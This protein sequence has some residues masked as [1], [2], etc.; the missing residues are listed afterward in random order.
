MSN[1]LSGLF[2][3]LFGT[4]GLL[5]A[6]IAARRKRPQLKLWVKG[7]GV[8][9]V[10]EPNDVHIFLHCKVDNLSSES[11]SISEAHF[12]FLNKRESEI[13]WNATNVKLYKLDPTS[14]DPKS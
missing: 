11:N 5:W 14:I 13:I 1:V 4:S 7:D 6:V 3:A 12:G 2:L 10:N 8:H 9:S